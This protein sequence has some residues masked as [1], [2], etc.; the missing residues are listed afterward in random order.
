MG[1]GCEKVLNEI[2]LIPADLCFPGGHSDDAAAA[3]PLRA[4]FAFCRPFNVAAVGNRDDASLV[5]DQV[6]EGNLSL[7][8]ENGCQSLGSVF[9]SKAEQALFDDYITTIC[10]TQTIEQIVGL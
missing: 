6:L 5:G 2:A 10:A 4:K 3:A 8:R 7:F 1:A 9:V